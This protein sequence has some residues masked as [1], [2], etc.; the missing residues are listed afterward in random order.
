MGLE[1]LESGFFGAFG[2][3]KFISIA[4]WDYIKPE[5]NALQ[6]HTLI[7]NAYRGLVFTMEE[8]TFHTINAFM[9]D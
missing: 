3:T 9:P 8:F 1:S 4:C 5:N 7:I 6:W 2:D